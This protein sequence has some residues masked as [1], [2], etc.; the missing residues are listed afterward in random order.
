MVRL[1]ARKGLAPREMVALAG[2]HTVGFSHCAEFA[3]RIYGYRGASHDPRLNPEFAR[4]LQRS[5]AGYRTDPT[6]SIFNDIVTPRD[7]DET[8]YKN[9][10]HGL[11]LLASDAAIWEYP[12]TRVF[13]QR[14]AANR[15]A[16]FEDFAA[17]MQRLGAVGVKTGRQGVVRRRCDAL[18]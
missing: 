18:D 7:F 5:C 3:P 9:L 13:A 8:Y 12:P 11:G 1:F 6:V 15:T 16:F 4:A 10:P 2:A 17:A 14:Y